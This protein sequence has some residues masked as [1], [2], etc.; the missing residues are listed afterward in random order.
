MQ[1]SHDQ[2]QTIRELMVA[3]VTYHV[4]PTPEN[5]GRIDRLLNKLEA[6]P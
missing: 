2:I 6:L 3:H 1:L 4:E 5:Y